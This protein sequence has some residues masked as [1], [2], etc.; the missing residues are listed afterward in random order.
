M[1]GRIAI[2]LFVVVL[3]G[4]GWW[5]V[6]SSPPR[7]AV[8]MPAPDFTATDLTT[9]KTVSLRDR[10]KGEVTLVNI[11][12][13]YCDPCKWE[14]PAM[15]SLYHTLGPRGLHIAAV[16]V[17]IVSPTVVKKFAADYHMSFDVLHDGSG[18]I[19]ET[20]QTTGVPESF[21]IDKSG[22][23]VRIAQ[24]AVRWN[25]PENQRIIEELLAAPA[26]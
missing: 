25:S 20:Y 6:H 14:I 16:S 2:V 24:R 22:H 7:V 13:T 23:I 11:W 9:G 4:G 10:Y 15:D 3:G 21:L 5:L 8:G 18:A 26:S 17:D 1:R 19:E 12:A